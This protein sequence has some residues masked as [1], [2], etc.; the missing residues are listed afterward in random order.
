M[1]SLRGNK[2]SLTIFNTTVKWKFLPKL[3]EWRNYFEGW[4]TSRDSKVST[5]FMHRLLTYQRMAGDYYENKDPKAL[6]FIIEACNSFYSEEFRREQEFYEFAVD[7]G[8]IINSMRN[9]LRVGSN[10]CLIRV[11]RFS[12]VYA[13]TINKRKPHNRKWGTTRNLFEGKYPMGWMK[14]KFIG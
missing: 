1:K 7:M 8:D 10:E 13:V 12:G 4:L 2:D 6:E 11:G 9:L 14:I 3:W 5:T